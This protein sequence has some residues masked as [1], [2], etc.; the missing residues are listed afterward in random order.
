MKIALSFQETE[1]KLAGYAEEA[2]AGQ[3]KRDAGDQ[4]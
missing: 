2:K 4:R 1:D 3:I